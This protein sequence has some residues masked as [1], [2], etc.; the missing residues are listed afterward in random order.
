MCTNIRQRNDDLAVKSARTQQRRIEH[1]GTV[2]RGDD[3]DALVAL[4]AVHLDEQLV[5]GLLALVMS[6]TQACATVTADGID[7]VDE[8]DAGRVF[9]GLLEHV[10]H[11]RSADAD[12]HLDEVGTGNRE[13]G[14]LGLAGDGARQQGLAG[15]GRAHHEHALGNLA[16]ELLE[17]ARVLQEV[18][19]LGHFL[20]GLIDARDVGERH[21]D[22]ILTQQ[23]CPALAERHGAAPARGPLHLTQEVDEHD[24]EHQRRGNLQEQLHHEVR[25]LRRTA[26]DRHVRLLQVADQHRVVGFRVVRPELRLVLADPGDRVALEDHRVDAAGLHIIQERGI[27]DLLRLAHRRHVPAEHSQQHQHDDDP[28]EDVFSQIVQG[29]DLDSNARRRPFENRSRPTYTNRNSLASKYISGLREP[30]ARG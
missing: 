8:D 17:L 26:F 14:N 5:E 9:L 21:V 29:V 24:D 16:A 1:V 12:E 3:D 20:L 15:A 2:G 23:A 19:D 6:A 4:E 25:L 11:A 27:A 13:E 18:D 7:F 22:L 10:A 30:Q 28:Q